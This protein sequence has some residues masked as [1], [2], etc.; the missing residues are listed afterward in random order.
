VDA[1]VKG[2][3]RLGEGDDNVRTRIGVVTPTLNADRYLDRT[4]A[5]VWSQDGDLIE[6]D[7][8]IVDGGSTDET[9][10]VA[11][12]YPCRT[13]VAS[14][15]GMYEAVNRGMRDVRG[16]VVG[17]INA[18]DEIAPGALGLVADAFRAHTEAQ[19]L[20]GRLEYMD[21]DDRLLGAWTPVSLSVRSYLGIG[22]SCIPQQTVWARRSFFDRVGPFDTRYRN[23]GDYEWY[24]RAL[25][26]SSPL[27][28]PR[29]LGRFRLHESNLSYDEEAMA[30]ESRMVQEEH[31]GRTLASFL[32]GKLLSLRLNARNPAWLLAKK[33]GKITFTPRHRPAPDREPPP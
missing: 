24:V 30:R 7:H 13:I 15:G 28:L 33:T 29:T 10:A 19:W 31:G 22:W 2:I 11:A 8:L 20:C 4:L 23:C 3:V 17:Y 16:D 21:G 32:A 1:V 18:D 9:L 27:I 5:S 6:I 14:D 26:L 12:R 25:K